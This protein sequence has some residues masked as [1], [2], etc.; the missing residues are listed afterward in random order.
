MCAALA[1]GCTTYYRRM[2]NP[3]ELSIGELRRL[4]KT[5]K[6]SEDAQKVETINALIWGK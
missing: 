4:I 5:T 1:M 6:A 3:D 2:Q